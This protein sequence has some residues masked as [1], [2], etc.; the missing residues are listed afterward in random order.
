MYLKWFVVNFL[1]LCQSTDNLNQLN[2]DL[3]SSFK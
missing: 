3:I 1:N 2:Q